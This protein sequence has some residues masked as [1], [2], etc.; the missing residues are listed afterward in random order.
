MRLADNHGKT[1]SLCA[2]VR[3]A[4]NISKAHEQEDP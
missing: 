4:P 1:R 2:N 3:S